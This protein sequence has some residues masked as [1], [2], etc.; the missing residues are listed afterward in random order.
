MPRPFCRRRIGWQPGKFNF[1]PEGVWPGS[2]DLIR[3]NLDELEAIRLVDLEGLYQEQA[4]DKMQVSRPTLARILESGRRKV[5]E[6]LVHGKGLVIGGGPVEVSPKP[7]E[8]GYGP[9]RSGRRDRPFHPRP[10]FFR[11]KG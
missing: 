11:R 2:A 5:A 3:L 4:A 10:G 1:F 6:A 8:P 7:F 9:A